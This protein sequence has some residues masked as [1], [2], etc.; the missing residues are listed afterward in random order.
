MYAMFVTT[1][2]PQLNAPSGGLRVSAMRSGRTEI[3]TGM[4]SGPVMP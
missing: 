3:V 1:P 2:L 4:P